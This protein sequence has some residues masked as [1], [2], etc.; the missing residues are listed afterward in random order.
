MAIK[1]Y[2]FG[3]TTLTDQDAKKFKSQA[4]HGRPKSAASDSA[5]RGSALL[6]QMKSN[7]RVVVTSKL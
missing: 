3:R 2:A 1:S 5:K 4:T 7:G 6:K